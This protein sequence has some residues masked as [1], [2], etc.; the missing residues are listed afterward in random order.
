MMPFFWVFLGVLLI[1][2]VLQAV[3]V[4]VYGADPIGALIVL[5]TMGVFLGAW[6]ALLLSQR[7]RRPGDP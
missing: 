4:L 7:R 1:W 3:G 2:G 6:V 5:A